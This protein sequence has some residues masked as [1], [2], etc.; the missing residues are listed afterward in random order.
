MPTY[1]ETFGPA[2][3]IFWWNIQLV[4]YMISPNRRLAAMKRRYKQLL[5]WP[6]AQMSRDERSRYVSY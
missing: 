5:G 6:T 1:A 4:N 2:A 3:G